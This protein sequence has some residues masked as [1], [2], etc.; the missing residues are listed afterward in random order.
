MD[1]PV[2]LLDPGAIPTWHGGHSLLRD[3][4]I[5]RLATGDLPFLSPA[6]MIIPCMVRMKP[7]LNLSIILW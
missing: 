1:L 7:L 2:L 3:M 4:T 6:D 5:S